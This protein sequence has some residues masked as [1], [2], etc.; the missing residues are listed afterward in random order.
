MARKTILVCDKCGN[1]VAEGR[2][3]RDATQLTRM[4][5]ADRSR[6]ISATTAPA[7]CRARR[8]L[9]GAAG[10]RPS[11]P[12]RPE[13]RVARRRRR[14]SLEVSALFALTQAAPRTKARPKPGLR[15]TDGPRAR[16]RAGACRQSRAAPRALSRRARS[17]SVAR[18]PEPL[19][20]RARRARSAPAAAGSARGAHRH[21]RR[22]VRARRCRRPRSAP[23]ASEVQRALA[24]RRAI[25]RA[26]STSL[27]LVRGHTRLRR[28]AARRA[29]RARLGSPRSRR[30]DGDLARLAAR[31]SGRARPARSPGPSRPP[32]G[33]VERLE[34]DLDA[35]NGEPVFAYGFED[36]TAAEW[37]LLEA[38]AARTDVTV[39]IPY[40]PGG[41]RSPLS[42]AR[43]RI[44]PG[45]LRAR[46]RSFPRRA[47]RCPP[48]LCPPRARALRRQPALGTAA[49]R[50][51]PLPRRRR[52][53]RD[54]RAPRERARRPRPSRDPAGSDR[55]R[56]RLA[57][58]LA[59]AARY[60]SRP[61][62]DPVCDR[63]PA[64]A[65]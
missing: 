54:R 17:R 41:P 38:L 55:R 31:V 7:G 46:S 65:R 2:G 8:S 49:R 18:R 25:A 1:E 40:E 12:C 61:A 44:L 39:S 34:S 64:A 63:A 57:R 14:G 42:S 53:P 13:R 33:A 37:A 16:R 51:A 23:V 59:G 5:A 27:A 56:L 21:V 29:R 15:W 24:A 36:L 58:A 45:S 48:A 62:R 4:P 26:S 9:G 32:T 43:S 6:P 22:P 52:G 30:L 60:R 35:W 11:R 28:H 19:R 50:I 10:Q 3:A 47:P 20:H